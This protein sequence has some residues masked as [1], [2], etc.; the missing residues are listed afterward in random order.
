MEKRLEFPGIDESGNVQVSALFIKGAKGLTKLASVS[1][2]LHKDITDFVASTKADSRYVYVMVNALGAGEY[3]GANINA[4]Y[5]EE[6]E[7]NPSDPSADW[8]YKTFLDAGVY[9]HHKNKITEKSYG[10]V[11]LAVYNPVMHRVELVIR[12]D[13]A[14]AAA[15]GHQDLLDTLDAGG[16]PSVSM[17]ARVKFDVCYICGNK[18]ATRDDYCVCMKTQKNQILP[19]GRKVCVKNPKPRFFDISFVAIGA[20]RTSFSMMKIASVGLAPDDASLVEK[21]ASKGKLANII[22]QL[23]GMSARLL[24]GVTSKEHDLSPAT[25]A[26][27]SRMPLDR[28]LTSLSASGVLLKPEEFG[29]LVLRTIGKGQLA[30]R[31]SGHPLPA[32]SSIDDGVQFGGPHQ[33]SNITSLLGGSLGGR[34]FFQPPLTRRIIIS[35]EVTP[36]EPVCKHAHVLLTDGEKELLN[37]ISA[38]YNGYRKQLFEKIGSIVSDITVRDGGLLSAIHQDSLEDYFLMGKRKEAGAPLQLLGLVPLA[39]LYGA[40]VNNKRAS[41]ADVGPVD[42]FVERHPVLAASVFG[43]LLRL[44]SML[45]KQGVLDDA[46]RA[47]AT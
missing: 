43:G 2:E 42:N 46:L 5:F 19:D 8:G 28:S 14:K 24:P 6:S 12:I 20:D 45:S 9:R 16:H 41:G 23:P 4:D 37:C 25:I 33:Y 1:S 40:H 17:G 47:L 38:G 15:E 36:S 35:I 44:G 27:L 11:L 18:S 21:V 29:E 30:E 22:K 26:A 34:S 39:Y 13:R 31:L 3:Y 10:K 7:L 32:T